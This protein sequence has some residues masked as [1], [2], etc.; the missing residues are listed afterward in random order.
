MLGIVRY[1]LGK[2]VEITRNK[3]ERERRK[4]ITF[5]PCIYVLIAECLRQGI[6]KWARP[7][8]SIRT[9]GQSN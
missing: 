9:N 3:K 1:L 6:R 7:A 4:I 8:H 2:I 5:G